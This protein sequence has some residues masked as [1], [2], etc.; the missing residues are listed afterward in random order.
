MVGFLSMG[1][2]L[3][4]LLTNAFFWEQANLLD[5]GKKPCFYATRALE[6]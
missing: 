2:K 6:M 4:L 1:I 3:H 5:L